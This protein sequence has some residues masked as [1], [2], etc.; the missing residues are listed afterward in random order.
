MTRREM[1]RRAGSG[2]GAVAL[3]GLLEAA[4]TNPLR[5]RDPPAPATA[6]SVIYLFMHGGASHVDTFD[7]KPELR[8]AAASRCLWN[9]PRQS[10]PASF[11]IPPKRSC[12]AAPGSSALA[13]VAAL[14]YPIYSRTCAAAWTTSP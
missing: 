10:R 9:W 3:S 6:K 8:A 12:A 1:L 4:R 7:P 11:T 13:A 2:F 5:P 14:R